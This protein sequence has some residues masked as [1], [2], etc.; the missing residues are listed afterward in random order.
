[1]NEYKCEIKC[2][3][4]ENVGLKLKDLP[5]MTVFTSCINGKQYL[6]LGDLSEVYS[7]FRLENYKP[8]GVVD[9]YTGK[10]VFHS[11]DVLVIPHRS[12]LT[13]QRG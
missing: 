8:T 4:Q 5:P 7:Y 12:T 6:K 1:M 13:M 10:V 11:D 3:A 9:I 2:S